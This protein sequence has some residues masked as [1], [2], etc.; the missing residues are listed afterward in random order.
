[1]RSAIST[2]DLLK[3]CGAIG[4]GN[5]TAVDKGADGGAVV[6]ASVRG[7]GA[8][9]ATVELWA[10]TSASTTGG[11]L[12][13]TFSLAG[14][15]R[16]DDAVALTAPWPYLFCNVAAISGTGALVTVEFAN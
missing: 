7:T 2:T 6:K 10:N 5:V 11:I 9:S 14:T 3:D 12:L 8:V 16:D 4:F 1:M 15:T 13:A